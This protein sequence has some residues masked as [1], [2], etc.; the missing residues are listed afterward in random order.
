MDQL[1][2]HVVLRVPGHADNVPPGLADE[3]PGLRGSRSAT[4]DWLET[5]VDSSSAGL[6]ALNRPRRDDLRDRRG[7]TS[8]TGAD[9]GPIRRTH[10]AGDST[11]VDSGDKCGD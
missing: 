6:C 5:H 3:L 4:L 2:H 8:A 9:N 10:S 11:A 1:R 7:N